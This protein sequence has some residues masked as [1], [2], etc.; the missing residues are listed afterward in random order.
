MNFLDIMASGEKHEK[1]ETKVKISLLLCLISVFLSF[2]LFFLSFV[3]QKDYQ[4]LVPVFWPIL[5][6]WSEKHLMNLHS[7]FLCDIISDVEVPS[8]TAAF[9]DVAPAAVFWS[10]LWD[11]SL[12]TFL[13]ADRAE[14]NS[15]WVASW[16]NVCVHMFVL[17]VD[18]CCF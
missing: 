1:R 11:V 3:L 10:E 2:F 7:W 14:V 8:R 16:E 15:Q 18:F 13:E 5:F 12:N 6:F 9:F 4:M 17:V